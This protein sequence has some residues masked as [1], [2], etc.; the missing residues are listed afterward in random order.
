MQQQTIVAHFDDR[1]TAEGAMNALVQAG[2]S[3][4]AIQLLPEGQTGYKRSG[5]SYDH[6]R[7]EGGFFSSLG[8]L[9]LPDEDRYSY[10][11]G[12]SRGGVTLAVTTDGAHADKVGDIL[13][14]HGAV[15]MDERETSWRKEGWT[16]YGAASTGATAP[17]TRTSGDAEAIPI[18]EEHLQVSKR[19]VEG[20]RVRVRSFVVE[21]PV[22]EQVRLRQ[23]HVEVERRPVDRPVTGSENPF[24]DRT[25]VVEA[26][27][28]E[29]VV[30]KQARVVEEVVVNKSVEERVET[31]SDTVRRTEVE[32]ED[33]RARTDRLSDTSEST[34]DPKRH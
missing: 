26:H 9:F 17:A 31:V 24:Q 29:A 33:E 8:N 22:E 4:D 23:E 19:Q 3:R 2:I 6:A 10:A 13:E 25:V 1:S 21:K 7:D 5:T 14:R 11:E 20:G 16:G 28:E 30:S 34:T 18:V 12:M 32:V 27:G 15:D